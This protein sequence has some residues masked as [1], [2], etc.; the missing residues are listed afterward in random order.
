MYPSQ[1]SMQ[2]L[3]VV[4]ES[5]ATTATTTTTVADRRIRTACGGVENVL[6]GPE[7]GLAETGVGYLLSS[8]GPCMAYAFLYVEPPRHGQ[9]PTATAG[10]GS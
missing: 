10:E 7:S 3:G 6:T 8:V 4:D 5:I 9:L 2:P 1:S